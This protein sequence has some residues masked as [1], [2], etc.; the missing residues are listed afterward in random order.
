M[1]DIQ[2]QFEEF[3]DAIKLKRFK[4]NKELREKRDIIIGK[5]KSGIKTKFE[6]MKK[7]VPSLEFIDQGSYAVDLGIVPEDKDYD[8]DEGVIFDLYKEDYTDSVEF[9]KII[10]DILAKPHKHPTKD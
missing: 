10:K 5:I 8:I 2:K 9:K 7:D 1:A 4:E 6:E 3:H